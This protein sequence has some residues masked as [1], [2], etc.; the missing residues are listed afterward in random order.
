MAMKRRGFLA[1]AL[2]ALSAGPLAWCAERIRP[3]PCAEARRASSYP[4]AVGPI[5]RSSV[6]RPG[7]W[8]G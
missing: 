1:L 7:K 3:Q 6:Q 8:A 4:G 5:D 2:G